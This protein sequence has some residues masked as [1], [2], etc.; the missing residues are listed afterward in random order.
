MKKLSTTLLI[1]WL[2]LLSVNVI[3]PNFYSSLFNILRFGGT[4]F[5]TSLDSLSNPSA[6]DSVATVSHSSQHANAN[7][8][9]E[10]IEAK[11]G[12]GASTPTANT[13]FY[14]SGVGTSAWS[15]TPSLTSLSLSSYL[16]TTGGVYASSTGVFDG[17]I[18]SIA[19]S[20][21]N[22]PFRFPSLSQGGLY[23]GTGGLVGSFATTTAVCSGDASCA[24]FT[25][26]GSTPVNISVIT[27][28]VTNYFATT[29][30][31]GSRMYLTLPLISLVAGDEVRIW[32]S[33]QVVSNG[34]VLNL[35]VRPTNYVASTTLF[36][37]KI[38]DTI[39]SVLSLLGSWTA[40][41]TSNVYIGLDGAL[42]TITDGDTS[43]MASVSH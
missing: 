14:G 24:A 10:A 41:T 17:G 26:I 5:P 30:S 34:T 43:L 40:T 42:T 23:V 6:G 18:L 4:N 39:T 7:D 33:S 22:A 16:K 21:F 36:S 1:L 32:A 19:S 25:A 15:D 9:L 27:G 3:F 13:V 2:L 8:A 35:Q 37:A 28:G 20:T 12:I 11:V 29:T 31:S 38:G